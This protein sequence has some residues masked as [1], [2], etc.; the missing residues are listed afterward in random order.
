MRQ[1][2]L[3]EDLVESFLDIMRNMNEADAWPCIPDPR[4]ET[5]WHRQ[6][7]DKCPLMREGG[8]ALR[9]HGPAHEDRI[10]ARR[11]RSSVR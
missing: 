9:H 4:Y 7:R 11:N 3:L 6:R 5:V 2:D 10:R 8:A 1:V